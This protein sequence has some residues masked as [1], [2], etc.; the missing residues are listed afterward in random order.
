MTEEL[1]KLAETEKYSSISL[2]MDDRGLKG[3]TKSAFDTALCEKF[4]ASFNYPKIFN[5][6]HADSQKEK[7]IQVCDFITHAIYQKFQRANDA[8]Y[9]LIDS[10]IVKIE[11][12]KGF[13]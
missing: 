7:G 1:L 12:A 8:W 2:I 11:D 4:G 10:K 9:K 3:L 6:F 13:L 5:I